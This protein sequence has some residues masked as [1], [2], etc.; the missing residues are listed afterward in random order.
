[1]N[2]KS[3]S[4]YF[5][6]L[7]EAKVSLRVDED[8]IDEDNFISQLIEAATGFAENYINKD[9]ASTTNTTTLLEFSGTVINIHEG[10]YR[11]ITSVTGSDSGL[12][13]SSAYTIEYFDSYFTIT[14]D[15]SISDETMIIVFETGYV[16]STYPAQIK[17][18]VQIKITDLYD[19]ER[20][21]YH[22]MTVKKE[23]VFETLLDFFQV[24]RFI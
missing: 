13:N 21:S 22:L 2:I 9:I 3:K 17:R 4:D 11:S 1:M 8:F 24:K 12:I 14:L 16:L 7:A 15:S 5:I 20:G 23:G 19:T 18:A 10:N 6:T